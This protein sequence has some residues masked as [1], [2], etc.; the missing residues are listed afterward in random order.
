MPLFI[1]LPFIQRC[2]KLALQFSRCH[3]HLWLLTKQA[4]KSIAN[5]DPLH[6]LGGGK[7]KSHS[8]SIL[9]VLIL[10]RGDLWSCG[11]NVNRLTCCTKLTQSDTVTCQSAQSIQSRTPSSQ[12]NEAPYG[13]T[14]YPR[15]TWIC[16]QLQGSLAYPFCYYLSLS[17]LVV[18]T[19]RNLRVNSIGP[20]LLLF[21]LSCLSKVCATFLLGSLALN[22]TFSQFSMTL[23][24]KS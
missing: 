21:W 3:P 11:I 15:W 4:S 10:D 6:S 5:M 24:P 19:K 18:S 16:F 12:E 23:S 9:L 8:N 20:Y 7:I 22:L 17:K 13:P 14:G 1:V 2:L